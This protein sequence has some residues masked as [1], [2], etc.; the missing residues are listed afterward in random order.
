ME[1]VKVKKLSKDAQIPQKQHRDDAAFD[2]CVPNDV[3]IHKGRNL[4]PL[5]FAIELPHGYAALMRARSGF[6]LKGMEA[7][8]GTRKDADVITG[9]ID[10][11]Y[12][13]NVGVIVKSNEDFVI[14][15]G[16]RIAQMQLY[17][18]PNLFFNDATELG[19]SS[20]GANGFGS[21]GK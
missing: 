9:L 5:D 1:A 16:T 11:N 19:D 10:E 6:S 8:D 18:V 4:I 14:S 2:V 21:T 12:R 20:R 7:C 3:T 17:A 15:K 13:G